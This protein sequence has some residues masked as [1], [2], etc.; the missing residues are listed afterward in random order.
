MAWRMAKTWHK[1][2]SEIF[3]IKDEVAAYYFDCAVY[4]FGVSYEGELDKAAKAGKSASAQKVAMDQVSQRWLND[5]LQ[6]P[7][8]ELSEFEIVPTEE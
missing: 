8:D 4:L 3:P 6:D 5:D 7:L 2:P 1:R